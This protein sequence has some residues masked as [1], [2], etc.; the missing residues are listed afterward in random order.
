M[1]AVPDSTVRTEPASATINRDVN[2]DV[3]GIPMF[4]GVAE[5]DALGL[6]VA[7]RTEVEYWVE[8]GV[9]HISP[10]NRSS[11]ETHE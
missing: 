7:E 11:V 2:G 8:D 10:A 5:L 1:S 3:I 6:D 9:V 4:L